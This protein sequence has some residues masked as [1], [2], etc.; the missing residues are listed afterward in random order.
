MRRSH[1]TLQ[2]YLLSSSNKL[3]ENTALLQEEQ[4]IVTDAYPLNPLH[5]LLYSKNM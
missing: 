1:F 2:L 5:R 3:K 4:N